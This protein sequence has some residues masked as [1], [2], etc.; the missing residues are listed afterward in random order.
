MEKVEVSYSYM[1]EWNILF[2]NIICMLKLDSLR[3][4]H[5]WNADR[6]EYLPNDG[7]SSEMIVDLACIVN[8]TADGALVLDFEWNV[9]FVLICLELVIWLDL[10]DMR[11]DERYLTWVTSCQIGVFS[12]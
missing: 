10:F 9:V 1:S 6:V 2:P 12:I 7:R 11:N 3:V 4:I 5:P 8:R